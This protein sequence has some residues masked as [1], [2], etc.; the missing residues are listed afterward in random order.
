MQST[1]IA[2]ADKSR[3]E[4]LTELLERVH[5][6]KSEFNGARPDNRLAERESYVRALDALNFFL[7][8]EGARET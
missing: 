7:R 5:R 6:A 2:T 1:R 8:S 4:I 3:Q